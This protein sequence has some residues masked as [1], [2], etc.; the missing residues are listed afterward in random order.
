[1]PLIV[2]PDLWRPILSYVQD[3]L[4]L[5]SLLVTNRLLHD[6]AERIL[7]HEFTNRFHSNSDVHRNAR[8]PHS[9]SISIDP[10]HLR[11]LRTRS[12]PQDIHFRGFG[13]DNTSSVG[14]VGSIMYSSCI[15][16]IS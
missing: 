8:E 3:D 11:H 6:E 1:M 9:G 15:S 5:L 2:P 14:F 16:M 10:T 12:E 13:M 4:T 7:Y